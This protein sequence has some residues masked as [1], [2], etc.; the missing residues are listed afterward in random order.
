MKEFKKVV[1][2]QCHTGCRQEAVIDDGKLLGVQPDMDFPKADLFASIVK[3]CPRANA[4][5]DYFYHP[6]RLNYPLKRSGERG[7]NKWQQISWGQA[8]DEIAEKM[9]MLIHEHGP[10]TIGT[11]AGTGRTTD[12]FRWRF[13]NL[14]GSPNMVG[15][16]EICY[17]EYLAL[18][19]AM[20][21]WKLFPVVR[22]ETQCVMVWGGGGPRYWNA[23]WR[24]IIKAHKEGTKVIV[25][26][27]RG[28]DTVRHADLWLQVRPGTDCALAMG[29]IRHIVEENLY[30]RDFVEKWCHG[31]DAL[32][33][34]VQPFTL[35]KVSEITWLPAEKIRQAAEWYA[36]LKPAAMT[37]GLGIEH[38]ANSMETLHAVFSLRAITGNIDVKGGDIFTT[39]YPDIIHEKEIELH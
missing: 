18:M 6:G 33:D 28:I 34:R 35:A 24:N 17:G 14:L 20:F 19:Y 16:G 3:A 21:G 5:V 27:P 23:L 12:E 32:C 2:I 30:Q 13:F 7:E 36:T 4:I 10:E 29:M 8:L 37:H 22:S 38:T 31:F 1:C 11:T 9:R 15:M 25:I 39:A 26:D